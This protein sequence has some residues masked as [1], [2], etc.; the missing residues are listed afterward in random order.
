MTTGP[1]RVAS[2]RSLRIAA[3]GSAFAAFASA[4][5]VIGSLPKPEPAVALERAQPRKLV[6]I[7]Q[8]TRRIVV[9]D[10]VPA[11]PTVT[12]VPGPVST[13]GPPPATSTGGSAP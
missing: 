4:W 10:P 2:K 5:G 7:K 8:V 12:F 9:Q 11:P 1:R 6:V 3:W 13:S